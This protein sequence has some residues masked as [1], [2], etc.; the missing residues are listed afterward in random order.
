MGKGKVLIQSRDSGIGTHTSKRKLKAKRELRPLKFDPPGQRLGDHSPPCGCLLEHA[1][2]QS[3]QD[4]LPKPR[5]TP[6]WNRVG[7]RLCLGQDGRWS[8]VPTVLVVRS[9]GGEGPSHQS[10]AE[11]PMGRSLNFAQTPILPGFAALDSR[12]KKDWLWALSLAM[13]Q[14]WTKLPHPTW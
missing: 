1:L 6:P 3:P 7:W 14:V 8:P 2:R 13:F 10:Q 5:A 4:Q 12:V 9:W 11:S